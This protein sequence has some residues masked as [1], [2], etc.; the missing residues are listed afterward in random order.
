MPSLPLQ[1]SGN[2]NDQV[3]VASMTPGQTALQLGISASFSATAA[4]LVFRNSAANVPG[5]PYCYL[6]EIHFT[7]ATAPASGTGLLYASVVDSTS[8]TPT[9][10]AAVGSPANGNAYAPTPVCTTGGNS[11]TIAGV[12]YFPNSTSGGG[13]IVI[14]AAGG[15]VRT[16]EGN[17]NLRSVIPVGAASSGV[18]DDYRIVFDDIG[19]TSVGLASTAGATRIVENHPPVALAP[20]QWYVL[21]LWSPSNAATGMAFAG[22]TMTWRELGWQ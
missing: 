20:Q 4:A 10:V 15:S 17:G 13:P 14:P 2:V 18:Q 19:I 21:Y 3:F 7:V 11:P 22:L 1:A 16:I 8:R 12:P 6:R 9:T 5:A